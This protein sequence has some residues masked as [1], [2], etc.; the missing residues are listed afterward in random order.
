[1]DWRKYLK[2]KNSS[3]QMCRMNTSFYD[4]LKK[5][6]VGKRKVKATMMKKENINKTVYENSPMKLSTPKRMIGN[7]ILKIIQ[8][9][10]KIKQIEKTNFQ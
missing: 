10:A 4:E 1:M 3:V 6:I 8:E 9:K 2:N 5:E 7:N